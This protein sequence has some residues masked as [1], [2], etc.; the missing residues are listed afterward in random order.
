MAQVSRATPTAAASTVSGG[1]TVSSARNVANVDGAP[2]EELS[3]K[4]GASLDDGAFH[5]DD[6]SKGRGSSQGRKS[7]PSVG[8]LRATSQAFA[9]F[10][11]FETSPEQGINSD[12][13]GGGAR[14]AAV[15]ARAIGTYETNARVISGGLTPLGSSLSLSL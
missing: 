11:E 8:T 10:L 13:G 3:P 2:I 5:F 7:E 15:V 4:V 1:R 6:F 14:F 12:I 9:A